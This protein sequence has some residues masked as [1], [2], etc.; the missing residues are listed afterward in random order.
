MTIERRLAR[1]GFTLTRDYPAPL[2]RVWDAFAD[3]DQKLAWWGAGDAIQPGEWA[4]DFRVGGR[5]IAEGKFAGVRADRRRHP[6][7]ARRARRLLRPVLGRRPEPRTRQPGPAQGFGQ[8]PRLTHL[9]RWGGGRATSPGRFRGPCGRWATAQPHL[10]PISE[11]LRHERLVGHRRPHVGHLPRTAC[12]RRSKIPG[13]RPPLLQTFWGCF[14]KTDDITRK[15]A[16]EEKVLAGLLAGFDLVKQ[17]VSGLIAE[18]EY[19]TDLAA[20]RFQTAWGTGTT[21]GLLTPASVPAPRRPR[22]R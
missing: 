7:H 20:S 21:S 5:D 9:P 3:E 11:E 16:A 1:A 17:I 22:A 8:L 18:G 14:G 15:N 12:F 2:E 6:V 10:T 4:F 13:S 19:R